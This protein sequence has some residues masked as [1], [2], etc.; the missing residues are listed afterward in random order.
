MV[1]WVSGSIPHGGPTELFFVLACDP[2]GWG[3]SH[4]ERFNSEPLSY[5]TFQ[6]VLHDWYNKDC[7]MCY[8]VCAMVHIIDPL[9]LIEKGST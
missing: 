3:F 2:L 4:K 9:L 5:I 1:Q 8:P 6:L 7:S